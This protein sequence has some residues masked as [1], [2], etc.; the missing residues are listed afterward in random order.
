M[1]KRQ[2]VLLN[3]KINAT[4]LH[5]KLDNRN[6]AETARDAQI[7]GFSCLDRQRSCLKRLEVN[8]GADQQPLFVR[9]S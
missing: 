5:D 3:V 4:M 2:R 6:G 9:L 1:P 8:Q 7:S